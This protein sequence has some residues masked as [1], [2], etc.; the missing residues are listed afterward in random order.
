MRLKLEEN[1]FPNEVPVTRFGECSV[2]IDAK[3][4][5]KK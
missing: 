5:F 1:S 2:W 4:F 3:S